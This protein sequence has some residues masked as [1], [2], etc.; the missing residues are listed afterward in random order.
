MASDVPDNVID[1][2]DIPAVVDAFR[3]LGPS[4]R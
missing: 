1:F 4:D 3:G 2:I